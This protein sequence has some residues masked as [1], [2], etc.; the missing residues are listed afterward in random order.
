M[1]TTFLCLTC[2]LFLLPACDEAPRF[3][4]N[5]EDAL[6]FYQ[7]GATLQ[8]QFYYNE[9]IERLD[10]ALA[11]DSSFAMAWGRLASIH[12]ELR[13]EEEAKRF[14]AAADRHVAGATLRERLYIRLWDRM[15]N[16]E[17]A[18]AAR[19]ADSLVS[20]FPSESEP[21]VLRGALYEDVAQ[22]DSAIFFYRKAVAI[23]TLNTRA[24]MHLGYAYSAAGDQDRAIESM[25]KYI[26][27]APGL[28]DPRASYADLLIRVGRYQEA[29]EQYK[30]S[31]EFKP[32]YWYS[33]NQIG[34]IYAI[35]GRLKE[36]EEY[37]R[38][39]LSRLPDNAMVESAV[40]IIVGELQMRRGNYREAE[41][42]Y[43]QALGYDSLSYEAAY[44]LVISLAKQGKFKEADQL[45]VGIQ[46]ELGRRQMLTSQ[47]MVSYHLMCSRVFFEKKQ[48]QAAREIC[49]EALRQA[50]PLT[51]TAVF[52]QLAD[53]SLH[54]KEYERGFLECEES[55][56]IN[57][58]SPSTLLLLAQLYRAKGDRSMTGEIGKRLL[59]LWKDADPDFKDLRDLRELLKP[60]GTVPS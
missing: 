30:A 53:I 3:S 24:V 32:D 48:Y 4:T 17:N 31:L 42:A 55:L 54:L 46:E 29:L 28:A 34:S 37:Y 40:P 47:V 59:V 1:K 57:R 52:R 56:Q 2:S 51:R 33:L 27:L 13:D 6:R 44:G 39:G 11:H 43:H 10:S 20:L 25:Q 19:V 21:L 49:E 12:R 18:E 36:A 7:E 15:I 60:A 9:A 5:S 38:K 50:T 23:D 16:F 8:M 58:N 45:A 14:I 41:A 22:L 26:R 35:L